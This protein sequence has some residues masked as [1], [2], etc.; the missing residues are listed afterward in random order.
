MA[1]LQLLR[2]TAAEMGKHGL[3]AND[4]LENRMK[5][6]VQRENSM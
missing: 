3:D 2:N 1:H 4:S 5:M 6:F